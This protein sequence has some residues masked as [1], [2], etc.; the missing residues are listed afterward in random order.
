MLYIDANG[1]IDAVR[2]TKKIF[3]SLHHG[4][5]G[6]VNGIVVHQTGAA[7][8]QSTFNSYQHANANGAHFIIDKDGTIYQTASLF[9]MTYHVGRM[10]SRCLITQKCEPAELKKATQ[11]ENAWRTKE[12][13]DRERQKPWP[14]RFPANTDAIGIE[15]VGE[16]FKTEDLKEYPDGRIFEAVNQH[17]SESLEWLVRELKS[18]LKIS[19]SEIFR[20]PEIARKNITEASSAKW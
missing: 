6:H 12:I 9:K 8:L 10:K 18:T 7:T 4:D 16:A 14:D 11:L 2:I 3:H 5:M 13:S 1:Y 17:Q 19:T 20:H 15:I